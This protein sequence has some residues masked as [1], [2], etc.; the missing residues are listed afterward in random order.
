[1]VVSSRHGTLRGPTRAEGGLFE[2]RYTAPGTPP[3]TPEQLVATWPERGAGSREQLPLQLVQGPVARVALELADPLVHLGS[4]VRVITRTWD[5]AGQRR[6]GAVVVPRSPLGSFSPPQEER[7]GVVVS[8]WTLPPRG[9]A[10]ETTLEVLAYGPAGTEPARLSVWVD[11]GVLY[12]GVTDLCGL[13]VPEQPLRVGDTEHMT[14]ADGT[15]ALG[16]VRPGRVDVVHGQWPGLRRTLDVVAEGGPVFPLDPP[17]RAPREERRV[18]LA[19]AVPVNVRLKVDGARVTYWMEDATGRVLE[20]REAHVW[21]SAGDK[22]AVE[23]KDGRGS[24]LVKHTGPLSVSVADVA[25]GVT[26]IA[27]VR[28]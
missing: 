2:W 10:P 13:P 26:A 5:A 27:E 15:V 16:P 4:T 6:P 8:S 22:S 12:A 21:L 24:F 7:P 28:P 3:E 18:R 14:G 9:E 19:P 25:T 17:L 20:G 23:V 1:V 11:G